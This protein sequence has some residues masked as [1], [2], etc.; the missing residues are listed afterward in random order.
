[1]KHQ[2][3]ALTFLFC[4][5]LSACTERSA[6]CSRAL[7]AISDSYDGPVAVLGGGEAYFSVGEECGV[8]LSGEYRFHEMLD[9][10]WQES[11]F[12]RS[13]LRP[14]HV[15]IRGYLREPSDGSKNMIFEVEAWDVILPMTSLEGADPVTRNAI[16]VL[17][18]Q[19]Q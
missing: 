13:H 14:V 15:S 11:S 10:A 5:S 16:E 6:L 2:L 17:S 4:L 12:V 3:A 19:Q 8:R 7:N 9:E 18:E 1:M